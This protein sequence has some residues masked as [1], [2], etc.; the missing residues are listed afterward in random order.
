ML[1]CLYTYVMHVWSYKGLMT[2]CLYI[3]YITEPCNAFYR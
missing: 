2:R 3:T 1:I